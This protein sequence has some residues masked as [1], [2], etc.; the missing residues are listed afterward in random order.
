MK[1]DKKYKS[2]IIGCGKIAGGYDAPGDKNILTHAH[3]IS[4]HK[5]TILSGVYDISYNKAKA[6]SRKWNTI[7]YKSSRDML[8]KVKPEIIYICVP[9]D[10]H[11]GILKMVLN[12]KPKAVI[13]EKPLSTDIEAAKLIVQKYKKN[14]I[15]L[16]VN[17]T[18]RFDPV[19][20]RIKSDLLKMKYGAFIN[21][22]V[23]YTKGILH[24][25]SHAIDLL[26][27]FFGEVVSCEVLAKNTDYKKEDPTLDA[28]L[29]FDNNAKAH[30]I[31]ADENH[32]SIFEI[33]L[34]F[35][36]K[37]I[38]LYQFGLKYDIQAVRI[39][40]VFVSYKDLDD[41]KMMFT[42]L[43]H[44]LSNL[45]DNVIDHIENKKDLLCSAED[46]VRTQESCEEL[47]NRL[48]KHKRQK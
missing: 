37:R 20:R 42:G 47:L 41:R 9:D 46:A 26:R 2:V 1:R 6:F 15:S 29:E 25:G 40:P 39:D 17:Y 21:A 22:S 10:M 27:Y 12:Y 16:A 36:R 43:N 23:I 34:L 8:G 33:D 28:F 48:K 44:A 3:A 19:I 31:A 24:N 32:Y 35:S 5:R 14:N 45:I 11:L 13:C 30:F 7:A 4:V 18:R 38:N